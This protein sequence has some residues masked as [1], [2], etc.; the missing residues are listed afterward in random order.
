MAWL[1]G[2]IESDKAV[3]HVI[4]LVSGFHSVSPLVNKDKRIMEAS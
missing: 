4:S 2:F 1:T 3:A